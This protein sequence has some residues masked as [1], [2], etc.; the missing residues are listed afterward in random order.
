MRL[1]RP[2]SALLLLTAVSWLT[3]AQ[4]A[5]PVALEQVEWPR[6]T[7]CGGCAVLQFGMLEIQLP[8]ALVG[9][10]YIATSMASSVHLIPPDGDPRHDVVLSC[11]SAQE[12]VD[13][14]GRKLSANQ[15]LEQ[16]GHPASSAD[17]WAKIR[18]VEG[19]DNA[20]R[21]TH[22]ARD[23]AHAYWIRSTPPNSQ[24][25][26]LVVDNAPD[27]Y[28]LSGALTPELYAAILANLRL[29]PAP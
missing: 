8:P 4:G 20:I 23:K 13:K 21:H 3:P 2:T 27:V 5:N 29:A 17:P 7:S 28:S 16:L 9:K 19:L 24:Y 22:T 25:T 11:T 6:N 26:Y 15:F 12:L 14:Y 18:R 10:I 1:T